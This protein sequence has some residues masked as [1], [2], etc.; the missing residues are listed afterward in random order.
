L[1]DRTFAVQERL[2]LPPLTI[3]SEFYT[4]AEM[5]AA[6]TFKKV[7]KKKRKLRKKLVVTADD[8]LG[9]ED[10]TGTDLGSRY[11]LPHDLPRFFVA[12]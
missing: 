12:L 2:T 3:A 1:I 11:L 7:T 5:E 10:N 4:H 9:L 8:L 6:E